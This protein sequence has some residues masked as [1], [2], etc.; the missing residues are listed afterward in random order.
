M[1]LEGEP[2]V[3]E[4]AIG[5]ESGIGAYC[6]HY[7]YISTCWE[8]YPRSDKCTNDQPKYDIVRCDQWNFTSGAYHQ[9]CSST[10]STR[11]GKSAECKQE[12]SWGDF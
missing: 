1:V 9:N 3:R 6:G 5:S 7:L 8:H 4:G 10:R 12:C 2:L 11:C